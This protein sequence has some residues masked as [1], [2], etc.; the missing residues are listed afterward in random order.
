MKQ[1]QDFYDIALL[2]RLQAFR[3]L[4]LPFYSSTRLKAWLERN[5]IAV[6]LANLFNLLSILWQQLSSARQAIVSQPFKNLAAAFGAA[7]VSQIAFVGINYIG[8]R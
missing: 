8:V 2:Q 3:E 7:V 5:K 4:G 6:M 1:L